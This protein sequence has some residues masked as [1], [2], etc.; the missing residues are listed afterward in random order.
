MTPTIIT[1]RTTAAGLLCI[2]RQDGAYQVS[3]YD[4]AAQ[5]PTIPLVA[6]RFW[7]YRAALARLEHA[8]QLCD[9]EDA[10]T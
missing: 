9:D 2:V 6:A 5:Q 10:Q 4:A 8:A 1:T 7:S 3:W